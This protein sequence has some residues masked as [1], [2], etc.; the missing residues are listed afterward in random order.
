MTLRR[1]TLVII[2]VT[3]FCLIMVLYFTSKVILLSSFTELEKQNTRLNVERATDA[4]FYNL[5]TLNSTVGD[6]ATWDDTYA[7]IEDAND[8]YIRSNLLDETFPGIGINLILYINSAGR[9]VF[10]KNFDLQNNTEITVPDSIR[11]HLTANS[12]ILSHQNEKSSVS[13]IVQLPE[14]PML[15]ASRPILTSEG[16]GPIRGTLIMG[17][18]LD[19]EKIQRLAETTHL[20]LSVER[21]NDLQMLPDFQSALS[22]LSVEAPIFVRPLNSENIA[23]YALLEDIYGN[24]ILMMRVDTPR[25]IYRQGLASMLYF[26]LSVLAVGVVFGVV[27][28]LLLERTVLSRLARLSASVTSIGADSDL[29]KRVPLTGSDELSSLAGTV[30]GML[31]TLE[32]SQ[33]G[34]RESEAK[35]KVLLNAIPD[36]ILQ[37]SRDG[38]FLDVKEAKNAV[39]L[40]Q[41]NELLGKKVHEVLPEELAKRIIYHIELALETN[42]I[43]TFEYRLPIN[44]VKHVQEARIVVSRE[45]EVLV[46]IR[47]ITERKKTEDQLEYLSLHDPLTGL[48]NRTYFEREM[49]RFEE[50]FPISAGIILCDVDGL[51]MINDTLGHGS[52]DALLVAAAQVIKK[53][54]R[55]GDV[56]A[57]IGGDEFAVM[58]PGSNK[59]DVESTS[60]RIRE[61]ISRYNAGNPEL[62]L[63]MSICF[64]SDSE[65]YIDYNDLFK[66]ADNNMYREKL[67]RS[68]SARSAIVQ[69]LMKALE[70]RDFIT[71][72]HA[73]R[74]QDLVAGLAMAIGL[75]TNKVADLRLL[76]QFH[77]IGKVGI[78]DRI[79]FKP[80]PLSGEEVLEMQRHC[81]IGHR[82]AQSAPDLVPIADWILKH[83]EW[84]DG[85]GYPLG[86]KGE[87]IP[88]ECRLLTIVDAYDAMTSDRPYRK[89]MT[90]EEVM[91]ELRRFSG[92]QFDPHIVEKF[93]GVAKARSD[94][95]RAYCSGFNLHQ[96]HNS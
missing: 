1:K 40:V 24:P 2:G 28:L 41:A 53:S 71:E 68:Q 70:A 45:D 29:S 22:S 66:E 82:I 51:K 69:T 62:P 52:G 89:A 56:V 36:L 50:V 17:R 26:I 87:E 88:L 60:H 18:Y 23:G 19:S 8:N 27:I 44:G 94:P 55:K 59:S 37:V 79:L 16:K 83:H 11:E 75:P 78:P 38:T 21:V 13:G 42:D 73:D 39:V 84:W 72:G 25:M 63:S 64:A 43:Q 35:V 5:S 57:R 92:T 85:S 61:A 10:E 74:M 93:I 48:Y 33:R 3:L 81:E 12:L 76:A 32:Q 90:H 67:H 9:I 6:W 30:N 20:S 58:M 65:S 49:R 31:E 14:G 80:G 86:L 34:L 54:L 95:D 96:L 91:N 47:D 46:I 4:I 15:I 77:D 7:F